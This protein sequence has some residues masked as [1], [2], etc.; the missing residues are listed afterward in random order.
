MNGRVSARNSWVWRFARTDSTSGSACSAASASGLSTD[1]SEIGSRLKSRSTL[2]PRR[3]AGPSAAK[4][5]LLSSAWARMRVWACSARRAEAFSPPGGDPPGPPSPPLPPSESVSAAARNVTR[6]SAL[7]P[8]AMRP[9]TAASS[10]A[11]RSAS[12]SAEGVM[13]WKDVSVRLLPS[14]LRLLLL[15]KVLMSLSSLIP[16]VVVACICGRWGL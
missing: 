7:S 3:A 6:T 10:A 16:P 4:T 15:K 9:N 2:A 12:R 14:T 11:L 1:T 5:L 8:R 13:G